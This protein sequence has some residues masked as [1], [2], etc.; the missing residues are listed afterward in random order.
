MSSV[1][2]FFLLMKSSGV[3]FL[4]KSWVENNEKV[5]LCWIYIIMFAHSLQWG[6]RSSM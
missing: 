2:F 6:L 1:V 5:L 3:A 4:C